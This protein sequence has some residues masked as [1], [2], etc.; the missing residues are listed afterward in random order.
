MEESNINFHNNNPFISVIVPVYNVEKYLAECLQS[1][2]GQT[3]QNIEIIVVDDGSTDSSKEICDAYADKYKQFHV[4]HQKNAG[5]SEARNTGINEASGKYLLFVDSDDMLADCTVIENLVEFL[6][7]TNAKITYCTSVIR[8]H[9]VVPA[10]SE[11]T[12]VDTKDNPDIF[13][14][15]ELYSYAVKHHTPFTAWSFVVSREYIINNQ[16]YFRTGIQHEDTEWI[17][18]IFYSVGEQIVFVFTNPFYFYRHNP[19]S[20]TSFF[21]QERVD[22]YILILSE[23]IKK[24]SLSSEKNARLFFTKWFNRYLYFMCLF[25]ENDCLKKSEL[26][27]NNI[28][29]VKRLFKNNYKI[30]TFRN[31]ILFMFL[32]VNPKVFFLL[33]RIVK[34][35]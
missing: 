26:F 30:L 32:Q 4:I 13:T 1:L 16:L 31:K 28:S 22:S 11:K 5:L 15:N 18:R 20:I 25:F 8:F 12:D 14:P 33:R 10:V 6:E 35:V 27:L 21:T 23:L 2:V 3:Y 24:I 19:S 7:R 9:E 17:P 29:T 34:K